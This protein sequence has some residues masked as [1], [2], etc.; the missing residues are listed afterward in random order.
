MAF[1][2]ARAPIKTTGHCKLPL[3]DALQFV[4][5]T[6]VPGTG[7]D[8]AQIKAQ[9]KVKDSASNAARH[10]TI[11]QADLSHELLRRGSR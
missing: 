5:G 4:S 9:A 6:S 10:T 2:F 3:Q 1:I 11:W 7:P 8:K